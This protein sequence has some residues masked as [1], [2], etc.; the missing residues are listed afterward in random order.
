V[1]RNNV[2]SIEVGGLYNARACSI[3]KYVIITDKLTRHFT[4]IAS[5]GRKLNW[6][7]NDVDVFLKMYEQV[8]L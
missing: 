2:S 5:D 7:N 1:K 3:P 8:V 6:S 4:F